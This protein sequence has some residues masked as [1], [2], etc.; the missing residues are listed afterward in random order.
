MS[1]EVKKIKVRGPL[2]VELAHD[3][4][5][6]GSKVSELSLSAPDDALI[7]E[8]DPEKKKPILQQLVPL[9]PFEGSVTNF[10]EKQLSLVGLAESDQQKAL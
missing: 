9:T 1:Q 2:L 7:F 3:Y 5:F 4:D 10:D 6:V 8:Q